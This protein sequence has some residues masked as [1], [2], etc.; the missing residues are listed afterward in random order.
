MN[1]TM[2]AC[3]AMAI[4]ALAVISG[5]QTEVVTPVVVTR[6]AVE[7]GEAS[8]SQGSAFRLTATVFDEFDESLSEA[9]VEWSSEDPTIVS[10]E[11][12]GAAQALSPGST[13]VWAR[14]NGVS[15]SAAVTV[16][17]S[18][19]CSHKGKDEKG[20]KGKDD[21]DDDDDDKD[22][23]DDDSDDDDNDDDDD[24]Q[25]DDDQDDDDG[26]EDDDD[27]GDGDDDDEARCAL[28]AIYDALMSLA[29]DVA[30]TR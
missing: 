17:P 16:M 21:D 2:M 29:S 8:V 6:V 28:P 19:N 27:E 20:K 15:G 9:A 24:D 14:F 30:A 13:L 3:I 22:D 18:L 23:D 4:G 25:D 10:V 11:V 5:C 12:D 26:D 7:P 1:S